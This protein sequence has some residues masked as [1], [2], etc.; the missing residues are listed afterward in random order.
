MISEDGKISHTHG[1][2]GHKKV[3]MAILL[4]AIYRLNAI[5]IKI[6]IEFF[7]ELERAIFKFL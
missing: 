7:I 2:A 5:P 3:K 1:L 4:N 6:S